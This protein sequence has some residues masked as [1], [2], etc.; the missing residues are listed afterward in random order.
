MKTIIIQ[1]HPEF[2]GRFE[3]V[4]ITQLN[5]PVIID[6]KELKGKVVDI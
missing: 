3:I 5:K 4:W 2:T 6:W 1:Q